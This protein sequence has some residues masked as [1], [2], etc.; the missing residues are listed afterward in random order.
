MGKRDAKGCSIIYSIP[1]SSG[2]ADTHP[3]THPV[4]LICKMVSAH[5]WTVRWSNLIEMVCAHSGVRILFL[6]FAAWPQ[7][8]MQLF[9]A[10]LPHLLKGLAAVPTFEEP[11]W[12]SKTVRCMKYGVWISGRSV[13]LVIL[14]DRRKKVPC[15]SSLGLQTKH[16][17]D[18]LRFSLQTTVELIHGQ[19]VTRG[20][21]NTH[22]DWE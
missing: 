11:G 3:A 9:W 5:T 22:L 18:S 20:G 4:W 19:W 17:G 6:Q 8:V 1:H 21:C 12:L 13:H 7:R 2:T 16:L 15:R 10:W 14:G